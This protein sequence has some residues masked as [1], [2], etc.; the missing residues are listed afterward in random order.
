[1]HYTQMNDLSDFAGEV[2]V[3]WNRVAVTSSE[4]GL[5]I[6]K[7]LKIQA[8]TILKEL[9]KV[10]R[11]PISRRGQRTVDKLQEREV[12]SQKL[13]TVIGFAAPTSLKRQLQR[14]KR[15]TGTSMSAQVRRRLK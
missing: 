9:L 11:G 15:R 14:E 6:L 10:R 3:T 12:A 13:D 5:P 2:G 1:M 7:Q 8:P 4:V